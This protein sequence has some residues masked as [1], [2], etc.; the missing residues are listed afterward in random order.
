M[1]DLV[2]VVITTYK[3]SD[4]I[5]N[6]IISVI[7]QTYKNIEIIVVDDNALLEDEREK[8]KKIVEKYKQVKYIQND[9]NLGGALS[10]NVGI[11]NAKGKFI[12]FLD[13]D[14]KYEKEKIEK[15]YNCYLQHKNDN[16]GLIY[17]YCYREDQYGNIIGSCK[18]D[19]EGNRI[20]ENML[21]CIAGTS[22]WF[23]PKE[24][25]ISVGM[26]EDTPC[27]QDSIM[28][29]KLL[30]NGYNIY[31][32]PENLVYYYEHGGNGI[33]G[34]KRSNIIGLQNYRNWCRKNYDKITKR[35]QDNVEFDFSK[36][37][38]TLYIFNDMKKEAKEELKNM[39]KRKPLNKKTWIS[40]GKIVFPKQYLRTLERKKN[41]QNSI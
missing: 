7:K 14:D 4:K 20:Y 28:L 31:R 32:V 22:L 1:E 3:R 21:G 8:T 26:F 10:R 18:N 37:L 17:C 24:A 6:A 16:A 39:I 29:L 40:L 23:C 15:Q 9:K 19:Y 13:D 27:K 34:T 35:Q 41:E 5:E 11:E 38:I 2:T 30:C 33:S 36:Q 12:A 25:L